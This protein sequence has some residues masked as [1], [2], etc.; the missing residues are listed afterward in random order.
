MREIWGA[1]AVALVA[2]GG[3]GRETP[4][5]GRGSAA[6][7]NWQDSVCDWASRCNPTLS[8]DSCDSQFQ[9][10]TCKSD[11]RASECTNE[12]DG[13]GCNT[14]PDRCDLDAIA[15]PTPATK[16]CDEL[17]GLLCQHSVDCGMATTRE[18][19]LKG[20]P[21]DCSRSVAYTLDYEACIDELGDLDCKSAD[22]PEICRTVIIA[23]H[24]ISQ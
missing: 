12:F 11:S 24:P 17:T 10:V 8:R 5:E 23:K 2:C 22:V 4:V 21:F 15:D 9:A 20:R 3:G 19:C 7:R 1:F 14:V 16:A 6:C 13:A 18:D